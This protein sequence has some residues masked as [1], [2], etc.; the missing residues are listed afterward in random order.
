MKKPLIGICPLWDKKKNSYW[1]LPEYMEGIEKSGGLPV[2]LPLTS[3]ETAIGQI[4]GLCDGFLF[5]GGHDVSP[6]IYFETPLTDKIDTCPERD[7]METV[8]LKQVLKADKPLFGIC[9]GLQFI[10]A[11]LG[12]T[13]YQD[14]PTQYNGA[15]HTQ[16]QPYDVPF[17]ANKVIKG[18]PLFSLS[19]SEQIQVNSC[20]HQ[21]V[22]NLSS[23]LKPMAVSED[24]L[25]EAAYMPDRKFVWLVQWHPEA[26]FAKDK[27]SQ[28]LFRS[29]VDSCRK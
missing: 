1:M 29:F 26:L 16:K 22:K 20:H 3:D 4:A 19:R 28:K 17:H 5:T 27:L 18:T 10:N 2:M 6:E 25:I 8:L 9:R 13:L 11:A 12:G 24:G 14:L 15:V 21:A 7:E 23:K